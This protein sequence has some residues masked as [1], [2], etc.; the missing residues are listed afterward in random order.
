MA[1]STGPRRGARDADSNG[2]GSEFPIP[3][4]QTNAAVGTNILALAGVFSLLT[5]D[6]FDRLL[7]VN[8]SAGVRAAL[9]VAVIA[10]WALVVCTDLLARAYARAH[11]DTGPADAGTTGSAGEAIPP[12][13]TA[14]VVSSGPEFLV[15]WIEG[16]DTHGW[17]VYSV[18]GDRAVIYKPGEQ[19][20]TVPLSELRAARAESNGH[21]PAAPA[22]V[23]PPRASSRGLT[24]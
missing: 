19:P 7:G 14:A 10:A 5:T 11:E 12:V 6:V 4:G 9:I 16:E 21:R 18:S 24:S 17:R 13:P 3:T 2:I 15:T 8:A 20:R 22:P 23:R 1:R